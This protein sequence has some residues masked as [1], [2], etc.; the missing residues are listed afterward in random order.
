MSAD[1]LNAVMDPTV[2]LRLSRSFAHIPAC[3][4][5]ENFARHALL[6]CHFDDG[7]GKSKALWP[8]VKVLVVWCDISVVDCVWGVSILAKR[9]GFALASEGSGRT[10]RSSIAQFERANHFVS[11]L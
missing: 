2:L 8:S 11:H 9:L 4:Y 3:V 5:Q 7:T 1:E 6:D 10:T